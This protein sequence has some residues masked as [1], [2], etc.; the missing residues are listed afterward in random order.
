M[1]QA[2]LLLS[3]SAAFVISFHIEYY[4][5]QKVLD[6]STKFAV[7]CGVVEFLYQKSMVHCVVR[8]RQVH[9]SGSSDLSYLV[10]IF[11]VLSQIQQ[12]T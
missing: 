8:C 2:I 12:L 3:P 6:N 5:G 11:Y 4:V 10:A 1:W 7:L 9:K